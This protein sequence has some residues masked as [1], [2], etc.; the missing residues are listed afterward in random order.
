MCWAPPFLFSFRAFS[1]FWAL[2]NLHT[3]HS[4]SLSASFV[5]GIICVQGPGTVVGVSLFFDIAPP[6]IL[7]AF[8]NQIVVKELKKIVE[9]SGIMR[10]SWMELWWLSGG[11]TLEPLPLEYTTDC[12][13]CLVAL[14]GGVTQWR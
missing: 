1:V 10:Y 3:R 8:V 12:S 4:D 5:S 6:A 9:D 14:W 7:T 2:S 13:W 11:D